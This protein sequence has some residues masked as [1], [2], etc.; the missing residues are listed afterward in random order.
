MGL[1]PEPTRG[2]ALR[3]RAEFAGRFHPGLWYRR[4]NRTAEAAGAAKS[5]RS[6]TEVRFG[7]G[8]SVDAAD[9]Y[10]RAAIAL[11]TK[12]NSGGRWL[13][14]SADDVRRA[15]A[16]LELEPGASL[17]DVTSQYR[18][19]AQAW[20][21]DR[22]SGSSRARA[23]ERMKRVNLA[24]DVLRRHLKEHPNG[25]PETA[26]SASR[27][28]ATY[29]TSSATEAERRRSAEQA[30]ERRRDAARQA[31][32]AE[33]RRLEML[34]RQTAEI[35]RIR[36]ERAMREQLA[37]MEAELAADP[38]MAKSATARGALSQAAWCAECRDYLWVGADGGCSNGHGRPSLR[39]LYEPARTDGPQPL[40]PPLPD[41]TPGHLHAAAPLPTP[42]RRI[43]IPVSGAEQECRRLGHAWGPPMPGEARNR[44][45]QR[46]G[47]W[48]GWKL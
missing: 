22:Y 23:E 5:P 28:S 6:S 34:A 11:P 1:H 41:G 37:A 18:F 16:D 7:I 35:R 31:E 4:E 19:F 40:F 44:Q 26:V 3:S 10:Y 17:V 21:P 36:K 25:R 32:A 13:R 12:S 14:D 30:E 15:Y 46:C 45:C 9:T 47:R 33:K 2:I 27:T 29:T 8:R 39:G 24:A 43:G 48:T 42:L 38:P 20:H